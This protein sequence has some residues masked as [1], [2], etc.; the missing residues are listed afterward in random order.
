[1]DK[2]MAMNSTPEI[3]AVGGLKGGWNEEQLSN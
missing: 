1:M 3:I 2:K